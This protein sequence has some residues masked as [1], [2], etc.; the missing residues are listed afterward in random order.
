MGRLIGEFVKG[1]VIS[2]AIVALGLVFGISIASGP[3][4]FVLL[5][6]L[7]ACWCVVFAGFMQIIGHRIPDAT[8]LWL[9]REKL[10]KASL[11][12]TLFERFDGYLAAQGYMA[13][14]GQ[15]VD[16]TIVPVPKVPSP[17]VMAAVN[18]PAMAL[19]LE[20]VKLASVAA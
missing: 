19:G 5:V 17:Q 14:G 2:V 7:S 13:R 4:G 3:L 1:A 16:A 12:G 9:F 8:T 15:M 20:S 6:L 11:I 18:W 10:A